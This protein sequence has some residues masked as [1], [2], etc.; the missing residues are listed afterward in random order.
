M[1][2]LFVNPAGILG[3]AER[4]LLDL[5]ASLRA[6]EPS[7][8]IGLLLFANGP[9]AEQAA[10]LGARTF[11]VPIPDA[12]A[13]LGD[14]GAIGRSRL[15]AL[16]RV[17]TQL[18]VAAPAVAGYLYRILAQV[19]SFNPDLVHSNGVKAHLLLTA[20]A[21]AGVPVVWHVRDFLGERP[22]VAK[23]MRAVCRSPRGAI[24]IS[25]AVANDA[26]QQ[27][28]GLPVHVVLN[29]IDVD[30]FAPGEVPVSPPWGGAHEAIEERPVRVGLVATYAR[31]KGQDLL[32]EAAALIRRRGRVRCHF[33][34][35]GGPLYRTEASQFSETELRQQ[36]RSLGIDD[37]V[38]FVP[39]QDDPAPVYRWLDIV[40]HASTRPEPFGRTIAEAMACGRPV[41]VARAGGAAELFHDG[42]QAIG[43]APSDPEALAGAIEDLVS[44]P[45]RRER[46]GQAAREAAVAR[47]SRA[48]LAT[49]MLPIYR[50]AT[51]GGAAGPDGAPWR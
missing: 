10:A 44:D 33:Y 12:L 25:Q 9:L 3:G 27:F 19:R 5:I 51:S 14:S 40:I 20:S 18:G 24:A 37:H 23:A 47:F 30:H 11:V 16:A 22:L 42:R 4:G 28:P 34:I 1:R 13:R 36:A 45:G 21:L 49:D 35:V 15:G 7:I 38:S 17:G 46:L 6:A 43:V 31:W 32:L 8:E 50:A 2:V 48:R 41:V 29:A 39:F 26:R